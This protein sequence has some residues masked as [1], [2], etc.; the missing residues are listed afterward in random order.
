MVTVAGTE[1]ADGL[2]LAKATRTGWLL[3]GV[4]VTVAL[5][6][7]PSMTCGI[8]SVS[9]RLGKSEL[10]TMT[11][12]I[13]PRYPPA[14]AEMATQTSAS[15]TPS[16]NTVAVNPAVATPAGMVKLPGTCK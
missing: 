6:V 12:E 2:E 10:A 9:A 5:T 13:A 8:A 7:R 1:S 11:C 14:L 15:G 16:S 3:A 4:L